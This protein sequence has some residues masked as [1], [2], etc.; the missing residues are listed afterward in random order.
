MQALFRSPSLDIFSKSQVVSTLTAAEIMM[1]NSL[2]TAQY[3]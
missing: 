3:K 2:F 1:K